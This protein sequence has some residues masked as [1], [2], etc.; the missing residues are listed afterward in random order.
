[1]Q[2]WSGGG[3][4]LAG[5][6][7]LMASTPAG[8]EFYTYGSRTAWRQAVNVF[9]GGPTV[10]RDP[11]QYFNAIG[12]PV[13][14]NIWSDVGVTLASSGQLTTGHSAA[15]GYTIASPPGTS[16]E[17]MFAAPIT[18]LW[19]NLGTPSGSITFRNGGAVLGSLSAGTFG[20][21]SSKPFDRVLHPHCGGSAALREIEFIQPVPG[22]DGAPVTMRPPTMRPWRRTPCPRLA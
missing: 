22:P 21:I 5:A 13:D 8:A 1:M 6:A 2:S 18:A 15:A 7:A 10:I 14:P 3:A 16:F 4:L 9:I 12:Q 20:M 11:G 17:I 19:Y